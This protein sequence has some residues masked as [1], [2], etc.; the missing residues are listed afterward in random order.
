MTPAAKS[1]ATSA[2][3]DAKT[4]ALTVLDNIIKDLADRKINVSPTPSKDATRPPPALNVSSLRNPENVQLA[5]KKAD[6]DGWMASITKEDAARRAYIKK[7]SMLRDTASRAARALTTSIDPSGGSQTI[8]QPAPSMPSLPDEAAV[9]A[10]GRQ[11]AAARSASSE[12]ESPDA[13][14]AEQELGIS[15]AQLRLQVG[16]LA[17]DQDRAV[18]TAAS[19]FKCALN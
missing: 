5:Q 17:W 1:N 9:L 16:F 15:F 2:P 12:V 3:S 19:G 10:Y 11:L 4:V 7:Y 8:A 18:L 6:L 14:D 13:V